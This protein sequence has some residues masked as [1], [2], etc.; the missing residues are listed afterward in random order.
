MDENSTAMPLT[1]EI[2]LRRRDPWID[3]EEE[4]SQFSDGDGTMNSLWQTPLVQRF[5]MMVRGPRLP[6]LNT[7]LAAVP[8]SETSPSSADTMTP[9]GLDN[10]IGARNVFDFGNFRPA[11]EDVY[12]RLDKFFPDHDL[13]KPVVDSVGT[14]EGNSPVLTEQV[15]LSSYIAP[16]P[17]DARQ[18]DRISTDDGRWHGVDKEVAHFRRRF[19]HEKSMRY[20]AGERKK[21]MDGT[22]KLGPDDAASTVLRKRSSKC[23]G[24]KMK[25]IPPDVYQ[26]FEDAS[27]GRAVGAPDSPIRPPDSPNAAPVSIED[28]LSAGVVPWV[29]GKLIGK[30]TYG[31]VYLAFDVKSG[32]VFAVKRVEM[33]ESASDRTDPKQK[34]LLEALKAESKILQD[35]DHSNVVQYLGF[36]QTSK[37]FSM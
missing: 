31:K 33:L 32:E 26:R 11:V 12:N 37:Y 25:E 10:K 8:G 19:G 7:S 6:L 27:T 9:H 5:S 16:L 3:E 1:Y 22:S 24:D 36:E 23:W 30:G 21:A 15:S 34:L 20:I 29:R 13:D 28:G 14:S 17:S 18:P 2:H 35:L 4:A